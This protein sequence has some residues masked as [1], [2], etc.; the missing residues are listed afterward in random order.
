MM[1]VASPVWDIIG[2]NGAGGD[3][4][5]FSEGFRPGDGGAFLV[6]ERWRREVVS[7]VRCPNPTF[8]GCLCGAVSMS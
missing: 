3:N 2:N 4:G 8:W 1:T 5:L 7:V 6:L